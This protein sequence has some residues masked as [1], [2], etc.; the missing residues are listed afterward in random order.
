M[1]STRW[2][3]WCGFESCCGQLIPSL[4]L[5]KKCIVSIK[6]A[7]RRVESINCLMISIT[8]ILRSRI[9]IRFYLVIVT[10][11][12]WITKL[13]LVFI[14]F[15][16]YNSLLCT[17]RFI[18]YLSNLIMIKTHDFIWYMVKISM[19]SYSASIIIHRIMQKNPGI[20]EII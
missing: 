9:K 19:L 10:H 12:T 15:Q 14:L 8:R 2:P 13:W 16:W 11:D 20:N 1:S 18:D 4:V 6:K 7:R 3:V 5:P 17:S